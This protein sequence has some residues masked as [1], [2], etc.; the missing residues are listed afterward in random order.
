MNKTHPSRNCKRGGGWFMSEGRSPP[1]LAVACKGVGFCR[2]CCG[3]RQ[4]QMSSTS[5]H[6]SLLS[7][8]LFIDLKKRMK[9]PHPVS[10]LQ[11]R[12]WVGRRNKPTPTCSCM[13]GGGLLSSCVALSFKSVISNVYKESIPCPLSLMTTGMMVVK[14]EKTAC[15]QDS[16]M[17][18]NGSNYRICHQ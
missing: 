15:E 8:S 2:C 7:S 14:E 5:L 17:T 9:K 16:R 13:Q 6:G 11:A 1:R 12:G 18:K 10:Q 3:C 4:T